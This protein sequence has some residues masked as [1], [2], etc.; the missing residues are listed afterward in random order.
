MRHGPPKMRDEL[1]NALYHKPAATQP[2]CALFAPGVYDRSAVGG[3][4]RGKQGVG[5]GVWKRPFVDLRPYT[6]QERWRK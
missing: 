2:R 6:L 1:P 3:G 4:G 5:C